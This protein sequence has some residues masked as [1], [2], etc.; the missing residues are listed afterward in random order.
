MIYLGEYSFTFE[1]KMKLGVGSQF[2]LGKYQLVILL[3][4]PEK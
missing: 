1:K 3:V 4:R 2:K